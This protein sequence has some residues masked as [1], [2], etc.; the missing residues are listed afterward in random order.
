MI[1]EFF[2]Q[3]YAEEPDKRV[4]EDEGVL[5]VKLC[6]DI[7]ER[8]ASNVIGEVV[9]STYDTLLVHFTSKE[10]V[11]SVFVDRNTLQWRLEY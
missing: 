5:I 6:D 9:E 3:F 7:A 8:T 1:P 4:T 11:E 2:A 10:G